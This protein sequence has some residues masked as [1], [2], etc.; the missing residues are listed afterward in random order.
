M[1]ITVIRNTYGK[2]AMDSTT[3]TISNLN[4]IQ[5]SLDI[6]SLKLSGSPCITPGISNVNVVNNLQNVSVDVENVNLFDAFDN[7]KRIIDMAYSTTENVFV[8]IV[9][10]GYPLYSFDGENWYRSNTNIFSDYINTSELIWVE[11]LNRFFIAVNGGRNGTNGGGVWSSQHGKDWVKSTTYKI[12]GSLG[13]YYQNAP[14]R[15]AYSPLHN[16]LVATSDGNGKD[17]LWTSNDNGLNFY[18]VLQEFLPN[19]SATDSNYHFYNIVWNS[20]LNIFMMGLSGDWSG[21]SNDTFWYSSDS[22][23][24]VWEPFTQVFDDNG[25][26]DTNI[27]KLLRLAYSPSLDITVAVGRAIY[28]TSYGSGS[29]NIANLQWHQTST[30]N[31]Q[32]ATV[33]DLL[34]VEWVGALGLFIA[35][36]NTNHPVMHS[37]DGILWK[38]SNVE[39]GTTGFLSQQKRSLTYGNNK[40]VISTNNPNP[41]IQSNNPLSG[42][43]INMTCTSLN[44]ITDAGS[45]KIITDAE[46]MKLNNLP[47]KITLSTGTTSPGSSS[48]DVNL[49]LL[50]RSSSNP[51]QGSYF[52]GTITVKYSGDGHTENIALFRGHISYTGGPTGELAVVT[53]TLQ[54]K[55]TNGADILFENNLPSSAIFRFVPSTTETYTWYIT[56]QE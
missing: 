42:P 15:I 40:L 12:D 56:I 50:F 3:T 49:L 41:F 8:A 32:S 22:A 14:A 52:V 16:L 48:M 46:R 43:T 31:D 5:S 38:H 11:Q 55:G 18:E 17:S 39:V 1:S 21:S 9:S 37:S 27:Q 26:V 36:G 30:V 13:T 24:I 54:G 47:E 2:I 35:T 19:F 6:G 45:G 4:G 53:H 28:Y 44:D 33:V 29:S 25:N 51:I 7:D 20:E 34:D 23:G 10:K